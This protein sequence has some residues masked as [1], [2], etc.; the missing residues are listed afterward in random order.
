ME[1]K[2]WKERLREFPFIRMYLLKKFKANSPR[3][4]GM[5]DIL[6]FVK[7][8]E[9][10]DLIDLISQEL[11]KAREEG[12]LEYILSLGWQDTNNEYVKEVL[13]DADR[14]AN[15]LSKLKDNK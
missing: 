7:D 8:K 1:K 5:A 3:E 6:T 13:E 11:D 10:H 9:F 14:I 4:Q 2:D 15:E 12:K